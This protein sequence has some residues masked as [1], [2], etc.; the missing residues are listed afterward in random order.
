M[1]THDE[2]FRALKIGEGRISGYLSI[3]FGV[4]SVLGVLCFVFPGTAPIARRTADR[5]SRQRW[6]PGP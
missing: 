4:L 1:V 3:A 6:L 5:D 2:Q